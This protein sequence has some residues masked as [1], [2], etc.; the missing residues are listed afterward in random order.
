MSYGNPLVGANFG[1]NVADYYQ[2][3]SGLLPGSANFSVLAAV[4]LRDPSQADQTYFGNLNGTTSG[5]KLGAVNNASPNFNL[6]LLVNYTGGDQTIDFIIAGSGGQARTVLF[7]FTI[8]GTAIQYY[9][10]GALIDAQTG[11]GAYAPFVSTPTLGNALGGGERALDSIH[12]A[13]YHNATISQANMREIWR[14]FRMTSSLRQAGES[15][16]GGFA[17]SYEIIDIAAP[18]TLG[19]P[20]TLPNGGTANNGDLTYQGPDA[21]PLYVDRDPDFSVAGTVPG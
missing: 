18:P 20:P 15:V 11:S 12:S 4:T 6:V 7:G 14:I 2:G 5:W 21:L 3:A 1:A 9:L 17:Y 16:L 19:V 13:M 8:N 10:N